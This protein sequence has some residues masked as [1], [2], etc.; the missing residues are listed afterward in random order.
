[1]VGIVAM[2]LVTVAMAGLGQLL[3]APMFFPWWASCLTA[4]FVVA[5]AM[6]SGLL[7]LTMLYRS[8]PVDLLQ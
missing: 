4:L 8:E 2:F 3:A 1:M 6:A 5:I 7:S